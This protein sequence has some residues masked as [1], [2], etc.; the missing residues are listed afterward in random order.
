M[1]PHKGLLIASLIWIIC[2]G[3]A[4]GGAVLRNLDVN[5][6]YLYA[7]VAAVPA[8][9]GI[10]LW[11]FL[12]REW[13]QITVILAWLALAIVA[14]IAI[15][16][17]PMAILFLCAPAAAALFEKEKVIEAMFLASVFAALIYYAGVQDNFTFLESM[18]SDVQSD[19]GQKA[20][21]A[22]T[23][24]FLIAAMYGAADAS[25]G[26]R[27]GE[28]LEPGILDALPGG[29][30]RVNGDND[31]AF[32]T[33]KAQMLFGMPENL[34]VIPATALFVTEKDRS[35]FS[36]MINQTRR[37]RTPI[38]R[39]FEIMDADDN[40]LHAEITTSPLA[41]DHVLVHVADRS[42]IATQFL[43]LDREKASARKDADNKSLF[44]AGVSHELRT[45]LNAIIGFSDM[46]RSRMF[47]PLPGKYAEYADMIHDSG[48]HMLDLIG[49]VLDMSKVEAG[50]YELNYSEF[51]AADVIRSSIKMIRPTADVSE[52]QIDAE[53]MDDQAELLIDADRKALRQMLLN[54]ISNAVKFTPK[55]GRVLVS[56]KTV[57]DILNITV[58]DNGVG[59]TAEELKTVALPFTQTTSGRQSDARGSGLGLSLVKSLAE[60]HGGRLAIASQPD[61]GTTADI[62]MPLIREDEDD[63]DA[64]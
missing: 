23:V 48:Q 3:A 55:G 45:P 18:A 28:T 32:A 21:I 38:A 33:D 61:M 35:A 63:E 26:I 46:M 16:F 14:C 24:A 11:P 20:G 10:I 49:D 56:A 51:D 29:V 54:L 42:E 58:S 34:G 7:G 39:N 30:L 41:H 9:L 17:V 59:M 57:G 44:F 25:K 60:L 8:V 12:R 22:A 36:D 31:L 6:L 43:N 52:V 40:L 64:E 19:W 62:Y 37:L 47:G 27:S 1:R 13:A 2:I 53:I 5:D 50:K 4:L 15:A